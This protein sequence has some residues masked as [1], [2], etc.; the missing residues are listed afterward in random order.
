[1]SDSLKFQIM[2]NWYMVHC[3]LQMKELQEYKIDPLS[4]NGTEPFSTLTIDQ[5]IMQTLGGIG[6]KTTFSRDLTIPHLDL[7]HFAH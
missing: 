1:M 6:G 5:V 3:Q 2:L 7:S 4:L